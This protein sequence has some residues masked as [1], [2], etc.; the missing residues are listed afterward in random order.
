MVESQLLC[1]IL[2]CTTFQGPRRVALS[3]P[4]DD[5]ADHGVG[6]RAIKPIPDVQTNNIMFKAS[7]SPGCGNLSVALISKYRPAAVGGIE[8]HLDMLLRHSCSLS[9]SYIL[10]TLLGEEPRNRYPVRQY[11]SLIYRLIRCEAKVAHFHGFD[12][13]TL[14]AT[15]VFLPGRIPVVITPHNG[16][17]GAASDRTSWRRRLKHALDAILFPAI[18]RR[19]WLIIALT[20]PERSYYL[21]RFRRSDPQ[22]VTLPNPVEPHPTEAGASGSVPNRFLVLARLDPVKRIQD[23]IDAIALLP[24]SVDCDI[25]GPDGGAAAELLIHADRLARGIH[26]HGPVHG[27]EKEYLFNTARALVISS[28]S[29]GL[30]TVALEAL[31]RGVPVI[32]SQAAADGLPRDGVYRYPTASVPDLA[33]VMVRFLDDAYFRE[34]SIAARRAAM[35]LVSINDYAAALRS[36]YLRSLSQERRT[37]VLARCGERL[38]STWWSRR[39]RGR[40]ER[41]KQLHS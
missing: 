39:A 15:L 17:A 1:L 41:S 22:V 23:V 2:G 29:E 24:C 37:L 10:T 7:A 25:A 4:R 27:T 3:D 8:H 32:C 30:P 31:A 11:M 6:R 5:R 19:G 9:T 35:N 38:A 12:R 20:P 26:F 36:I 14:I 13:L 16:V 34:A 21:A 28:E 40:S 33:R 18:L